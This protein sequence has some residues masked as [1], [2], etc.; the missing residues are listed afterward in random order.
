MFIV[1]QPL[2]TKKRSLNDGAKNTGEKSDKN[3]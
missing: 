1:L 2:K 3:L